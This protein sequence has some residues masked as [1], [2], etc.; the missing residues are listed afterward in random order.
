MYMF[1]MMHLLGSFPR[2]TEGWTIVLDHSW[3][4]I[5]MLVFVLDVHMLMFVLATQLDFPLV[6]CCSTYGTWVVFALCD[7][8]MSTLA[9][10]SIFR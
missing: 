7:S 5:S 6:Q 2:R 8:S 10:Q 9:F 1:D 4:G 3:Q